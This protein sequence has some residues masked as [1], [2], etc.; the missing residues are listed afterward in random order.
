MPPVAA[1]LAAGFSRYSMRNL[2]IFFPNVWDSGSL[3][4]ARPKVI[5]GL[6]GT[7]LLIDALIGS[8]HDLCSTVFDPTDVAVVLAHSLTSF[9]LYLDLSAVPA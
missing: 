6:D 3:L 5:A 7:F 4:L 1:L 2:F 8:L 9:L